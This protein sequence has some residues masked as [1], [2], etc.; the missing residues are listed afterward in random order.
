MSTRRAAILKNRKVSLLYDRSSGVSYGRQSGITAVR[1]AKP[2]IHAL[3]MV[4]SPEGATQGH[5]TKRSRFITTRRSQFAAFR[6]QAMRE[7][8]A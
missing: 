1:I 4:A 2:F 3:D 5:R 7:A 6:E 8:A